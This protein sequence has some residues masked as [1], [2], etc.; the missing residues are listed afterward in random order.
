MSATRLLVSYSEISTSYEREERLDLAEY[1]FADV[2]LMDGERVDTVLDLMGGDGS[3]NDSKRRLLLL[4][5]RRVIHLDGK[6]RNPRAVFALLEDVDAVETG[7]EDE[8]PGAFVW[9]GL[10]FVAALFLYFV[11]DNV[12][13]RISGTVAVALLGV[14]LIGDRMVSSGAPVLV[15]RAGPA[16]LRCGLRNGRALDDAY[17]FINRVFELKS[18]AAS[19]AA[20]INRFAPR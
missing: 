14:Y 16:E 2:D 11:I 9:A 5:D 13:G 1:G 8:G 20:R 6:T 17:P 19:P 4:T 10:A 18:D 3:R 15:F 7:A 12:A